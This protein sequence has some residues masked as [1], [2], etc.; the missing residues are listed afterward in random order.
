MLTDLIN[1][2]IFN[3]LVDLVLDLDSSLDEPVN[4]EVFSFGTLV[5]SGRDLFSKAITPL[6]EEVMAVLRRRVKTGPLFG[7]RIVM[8][9]PNPKDPNVPNEDV[10]EE[11]PYHL[12]DYDEEED[13]E[14]DIKEDEPEEDLVEEP[15]P[16]AGHGDQFDAHP[17]PQ[18]GNMNG[19]VDNND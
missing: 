1:N 18:L 5:D 15:E 10:S 3:L 4:L 9:N 19:W 12:L 8:A 13:P 2:M 11:D 16:L 17:N 14:M 6:D 7:K